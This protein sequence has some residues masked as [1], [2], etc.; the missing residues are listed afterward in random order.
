MFRRRTTP[1]RS[2]DELVLM[3]SAGVLV[4]GALHAVCDAAV[5]GVTTLEL[6][7]LA[8]AFLEDRGAVPSFPEVP[9]YRHTLCTSVNEQ[10]VH[11][12]PGPLVLHEGDLLSV[13]CGASVSGWHADAA[14]TVVVGGQAAASEQD[15]RLL[16]TTDAALWA[17]IAALRVG[18][19]L[20]AVGEAVEAAVQQLGRRH[21]LAYGIVE[22][23]VGHGIGRRMHEDPQIFNYAV[24]ER[25]PL[26]QPGFVGAIEPMV[27][28]GPPETV[29][30][31]DGWTVVT[32]DGSRAAHFE[33]TVAARKAGL[34]VLTAEDGGA[35][36]LAALGAPYAP[37]A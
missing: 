1:S 33:H 31:A 11:G 35:S 20:H 10:V 25:G 7:R 27:T 8:Q 23:Y 17:G 36:R 6:D 32:A 14:L 4:A 37:V 19:R 26:V 13:D 15:R 34:W 16:E 2:D 22:D 21:G 18:Q 5:P 3:R 29:V 9:G 30:L 24:R 28:L 12:I